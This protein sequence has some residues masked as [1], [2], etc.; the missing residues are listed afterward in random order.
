MIKIG[1]HCCGTNGKF[2]NLKSK[3]GNRCCGKTKND[4]DD[5][6]FAEDFYA[7]ISYRTL[8][9]ELHSTKSE[10]RECRLM[11]GTGSHSQTHL[12]PDKLLRYIN[13]LTSRRQDIVNRIEQL[14]IKAFPAMQNM[15]ELTIG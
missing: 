6:R 1:K 10:I 15:E 14:F 5:T 12:H 11:L 9:H 13:M 2:A 3:I 7:C 4:K 8:K